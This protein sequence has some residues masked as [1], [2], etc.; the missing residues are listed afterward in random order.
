MLDTIKVGDTV[1]YARF[2]RYGVAA[3]GFGTITKINGFGHIFLTATDGRELRFDKYGDSYKNNYGPS[4]IGA[5]RL[6]EIVERAENERIVNAK[7]NAIADLVASVRCGNGRMAMS[8]ET[9]DEIVALV[10]Q[11]RDRV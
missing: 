1:G 7:S 11:L 9:L 2:T 3:N 6:T 4:L 5:A 10:A 8:N